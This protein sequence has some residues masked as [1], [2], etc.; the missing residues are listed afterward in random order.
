VWVASPTDRPGGAKFC[1][2]AQLTE[3]SKERSVLRDHNLHVV[4]GV[5]LMAVLGASSVGPALP[6]VAD[7][8]GVSSGQVGLLITVF[9]LPGVVLT[10]IWGVLSDRYGRKKI[11]VPSLLL[12]GV[13][14]ASCALARSFELLM[15]LRLV[16]GAGAAALGAIN[17]TVIGDLYSGHERTE[18]MGYNSSVLSIGTAGYPVIGGM[19]ATLGWYYPF[20]LPLVAVPIGLLVLFSLRNPEPAGDS[21]LKEYFGSV[22]EHLKDRR[23]IGLFAASLVTFIILY[24]PQITYLPILMDQSFGASPV[25]TGAIVS[26]SSVV[27][28][29]TAT[30]LRRLTRLVSEKILIRVAFVLYAVALCIVPLVPSL[31]LLLVA[32]AVYG[33]AQGINIP[34]I[35]SLLTGYAPQE[36]RGAILSLNGTIL[37]L[38]QTLGPLLMGLAAATL[39]IGGAYFAGAALAAAMFLVALI[40]IR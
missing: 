10:P 17:V 6:K 24:G 32:T 29:L 31:P 39:S 20:A 28:A 16:Q 12:F 27:T 34:N 25:I 3:E 7:E 5:T 22:A 33:F 23:V 40:L 35:L 18:A 26:S 19:L 11:L 8:L 9:T 4:F 30:Q 1:R 21:G 2:V 14:G 38:G 37:R 13:A 36:N 15:V